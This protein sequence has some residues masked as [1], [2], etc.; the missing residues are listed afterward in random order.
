MPGDPKEC[1]VHARNCRKLA[2]T[3]RNA[4][5]AENFL[6]LAETWDSL[7]GELES[8][9]VFLATMNAIEPDQSET[10]KAA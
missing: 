3:A 8:N 1:R 4:E 7:A 6:L 5:A 2:L 10:T 9:H